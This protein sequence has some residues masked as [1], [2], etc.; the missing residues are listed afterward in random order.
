MEEREKVERVECGAF[1]LVSCSL[2]FLLLGEEEEGGGGR[3]DCA[4]QLLRDPST[5]IFVA[6]ALM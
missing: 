2:F 1:L 5:Y 4:G 3:F 6:F